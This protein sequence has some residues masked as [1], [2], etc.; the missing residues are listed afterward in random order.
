MRPRILTCALGL[1]LATGPAFAQTNVGQ[2]SG[3]NGQY[4]FAGFLSVGVEQTDWGALQDEL[5]RTDFA[6][7]REQR[8]TIGGGGYALRSHV[9]VGAG[10]TRWRLR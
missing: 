3:R 5:T 1:V 2:A 9:L 8:F 10:G 7:L 6:R 4:G